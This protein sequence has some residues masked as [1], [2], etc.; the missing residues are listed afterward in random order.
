MFR[1]L[2]VEDN[3]MNSDMLSRRLRRQ[4]W[5][6]SLATT[7]REAVDMATDNIPDLILM[8][9]SLPEIDGWTATRILREHTAT[10]DVLVIALTAHAMS[11]DCER[12]LQ[13]G[14]DGFET[15][16]IDFARLLATIASLTATREHPCA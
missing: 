10:H 6:V 5:Q 1:V 11:G 3:E 14:C 16:P 12:A 2:L 7:G 15:K 8:D 13:A 9:L 4:G